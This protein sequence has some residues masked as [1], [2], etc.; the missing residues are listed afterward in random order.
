M[1]LMCSL[2]LLTGLA[3]VSQ[4]S[5]DNPQPAKA[6]VPVV[7][8][9][10]DPLAF[11]QLTSATPN[12]VYQA[13]APVTSLE[14]GLSYVRKVS[15]RPIIAMSESKGWYFYATAVGRGENGRLVFFISGYAIKRDGRQVIQWSVW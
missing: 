3:V 14:S 5:P 11:R 8:D 4:G 10:V 6:A 1:R 2:V 15:N 9:V 12:V 7:N 13:P